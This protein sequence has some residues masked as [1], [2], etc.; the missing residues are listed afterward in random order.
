MNLK[1]HLLLRIIL[2]AFFCLLSTSAYVLYQADR[3]TKLESQ[4]TL[5]SIVK[6]LQMQLLRINVGL[7][8]ADKFPDLALWQETREV[9]GVC[10]HFS[11]ADNSVTRNIC[12]GP[13]WSDRQWPD[14]FETLYKTLFHPGLE[15][16]RPVIFKSKEQGIISLNPSVEKELSHA[17]ES[18]RVLLTLSVFTI[19]GV[20]LLV[21][22]SIRQTLRPAE[23]IVSGLTKMQQ[24]DLNIRL[25]DFD[26]V[27]W[28][29]TATAI[30]ELV[31]TQQ[32]LLVERQHLS[33]KLISLQDEERRYL[34]RELHDELGQCLAA[35]NALAS[36]IAQT[37]A[38]ECPA[39]VAEAKNISRINGHV[40]QT[41]RD[42]LH[43]LR[44]AEIDEL[45]LEASL[46]SLI[47]EWNSVANNKIH[48][49]LVI[50]ADCSQLVKPLPT[51]LFRIIQEGL[52][53][54]AKHSG[55][56]S[57]LVELTSKNESLLLNIEDNGRDVELP[58]SSTAGIG[59]LGI[60]ERVH[61]V[62]GQFK[63]H[64]SPSGGLNMLISF[65]LLDNS[66]S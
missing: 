3:Q 43:H 14:I 7:E 8:H 40:M 16:S 41:V 23:D 65:P 30:N 46:N 15:I 45:G 31:N 2:V 21:Y 49:R 61:A 32:Q 26:I 59:L 56:S 66:K 35:V 44:S 63:L 12:R 62:G 9:V 1:F 25:P 29:Q 51:T 50:H 20:C 42:L 36:S 13:A 47:S 6:Q 24:G 57:A 27:E 54:I 39:L 34:A 48:Y 28:Q 10:I 4:S 52:T 5:D 22:L 33:Y 38:I 18:L 17:W 64:N 60:R 53:N 19:V 11:S 58:F 55:A 37:A